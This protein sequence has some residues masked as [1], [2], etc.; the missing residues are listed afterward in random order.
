MELSM[1]WAVNSR[2]VL[3]VLFL[4]LQVCIQKNA[5]VGVI[6][7]IWWA[8]DIPSTGRK[9]KERDVDFG[10]ILALSLFRTHQTSHIDMRCN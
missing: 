2:F 4:L 9:Q 10:D 1:L 3:C 5:T 6:V 7:T 8:C